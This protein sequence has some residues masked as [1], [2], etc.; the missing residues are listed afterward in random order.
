[1]W[2]YGYLF[3]LCS[4]GAGFLGCAGWVFSALLCAGLGLVFSLIADDNSRRP[5]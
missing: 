5:R 4:F 1:M 3:G 2:P